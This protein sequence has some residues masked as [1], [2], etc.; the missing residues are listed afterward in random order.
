MRKVPR[1]I[2]LVAMQNYKISADAKGFL[3]VDPKHIKNAR[4]TILVELIFYSSKWHHT[5][6]AEYLCVR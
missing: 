2:V 3:S 1:V 6:L 4:F 5:P